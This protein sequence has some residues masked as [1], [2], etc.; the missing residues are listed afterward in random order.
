MQVYGPAV[1]A[2]SSLGGG[3]GSQFMESNVATEGSEKYPQSSRHLTLV[4]SRR[5]SAAI[6]LQHWLDR[7]MHTLFVKFPNVTDGIE[8]TRKGKQASWRVHARRVREA[9]FALVLSGQDDQVVDEVPALWARFIERCRDSAKRRR[10]I[11]PPRRP[12]GDFPVAA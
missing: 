9:V 4:K 12:S 11:T 10:S 1:S 8:D 7:E 3:R 2:G 6:D 5:S